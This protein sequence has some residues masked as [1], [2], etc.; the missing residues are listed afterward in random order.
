[1]SDLIAGWAAILSTALAAIKVWEVFQDRPHLQTSYSFS[2]SPDHE[3]LIVIINSG[4]TPALVG[5]W[6]LTWAQRYW[7]WTRFE[8]LE[9]AA[10]DGRCDMTIPAH[11][12][13]RLI[14]QEQNWF[15]T[16]DKIGGR[17]VGLYLKL[18]LAG[19]RRCLWLKVWDSKR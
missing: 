7:F 8:R 10:D 5:Y 2:G 4:S 12:R 17:P 3:N 6:E 14:F 13:V 11:D 19:R 9:E 15:P 18:Y 1:M 16:R